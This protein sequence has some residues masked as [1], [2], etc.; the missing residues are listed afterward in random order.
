MFGFSLRE[1]YVKL[2]LCLTNKNIVHLIHSCS[3]S[4]YTVIYY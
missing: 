3:F 1:I 2:Q 4:V